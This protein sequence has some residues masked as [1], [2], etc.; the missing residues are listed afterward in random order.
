[1]AAMRSPR[2]PWVIIYR[3]WKPRTRR[4]GRAHRGGRH[5]PPRVLPAGRGSS[6]GSTVVREAPVR[7]CD[8]QTGAVEELL[9]LMVMGRAA[10]L[11]VVM[12]RPGS[13]DAV[14]CMS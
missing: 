11:A 1:M 8:P 14:V 5:R 4:P 2:R 6:P 3:R 9:P 12:V 7:G 13:A 10:P